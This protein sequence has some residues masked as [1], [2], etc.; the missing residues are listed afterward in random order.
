MKK[1]KKKPK[2]SADGSRLSAWSYYVDTAL[3]EEVCAHVEA[4]EE[5][6]NVAYLLDLFTCPKAMKLLEKVKKQEVKKACQKKS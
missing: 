2:C 3:L 5:E 4:A 1:N 6:A